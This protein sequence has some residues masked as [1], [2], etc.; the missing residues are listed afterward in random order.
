MGVTM[1]SKMAAASRV[2]QVA[3]RDG[4]H[5]GGGSALGPAA[6]LA[7]RGDRDRDRDRGPSLAAGEAQRRRPDLPPGSECRRGPR[8]RL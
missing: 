4:T 6:L 3:G 5:R 1:G 2:V 8:A 7:G